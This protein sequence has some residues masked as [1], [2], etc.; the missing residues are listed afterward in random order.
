MCGEGEGQDGVASGGSPEADTF[1]AKKVLSSLV[2]RS[3]GE[4]DDARE[5]EKV[6]GRLFGVGDNSTGFGP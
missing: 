5:R 6:K 4:S 1:Q 3:R 2:C